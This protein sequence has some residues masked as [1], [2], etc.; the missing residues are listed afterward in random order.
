MFKYTKTTLKKMEDLFSELEYT[1]RYERGTFQS[2]Y[3]LVE[4]RKIAVINRFFDAEARINTLMDI[5]S[6]LEVDVEQLTEKT[7]EF[8]RQAKK[9]MVAAAEAEDAQ[10]QPSS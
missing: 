10:S 5:L 8:Y 7:A 9:A 6:T 4:K 3:C 2:G 1:I